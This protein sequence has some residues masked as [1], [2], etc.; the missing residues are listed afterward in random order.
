MF[1]GPLTVKGL[2]N[3]FG[4]YCITRSERNSFSGKAHTKNK[5]A[6][7]KNKRSN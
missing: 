2:Q 6:I 7:W 1:L 5:D 4:K 3:Q